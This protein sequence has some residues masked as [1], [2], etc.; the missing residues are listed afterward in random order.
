MGVH[1]RSD[2]E[3][4]RH[5]LEWEVG[6]LVDGL[7]EGCRKTSEHSGRRHACGSEYRGYRK[8]YWLFRTVCE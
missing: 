7:D 1:N 8:G 2:E 4:L 6:M 5:A 3:Y